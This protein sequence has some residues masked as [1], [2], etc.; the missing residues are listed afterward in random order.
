M[1]R[2]TEKENKHDFTRQIHSTARANTRFANMPNHDE[3]KAKESGKVCCHDCRY[4]DYGCSEF[5]GRY[6]KPCTEF[7]WW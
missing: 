2:K 4:F 5:I 6:H 1:A 3:K 7:E